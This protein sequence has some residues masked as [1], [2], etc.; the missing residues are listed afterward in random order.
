[1]PKFPPDLCTHAASSFGVVE[2]GPTRELPE[3]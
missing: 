1:M 3:P 2:R